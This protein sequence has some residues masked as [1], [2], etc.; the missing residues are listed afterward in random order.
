MILICVIDIVKR[1]LLALVTAIFPQAL[2]QRPCKIR[3][4]V[5]QNMLWLR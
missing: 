1:I 2:Q 3:C 4:C 5:K